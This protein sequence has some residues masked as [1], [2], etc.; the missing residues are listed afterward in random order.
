MALTM[1]ETSG[2]LGWLAAALLFAAGAAWSKV[3][4]G[5]LLERPKNGRAAR[6]EQVEGASRLLVAAVSLSAAAAGL[7]IFGMMFG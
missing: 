5:P 2:L 7:A 1:L 4:L 3:G 6:N